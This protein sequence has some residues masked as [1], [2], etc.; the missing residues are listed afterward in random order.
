MERRKFM[1][2]LG[3]AAAGSAALVGSGAFSAMTS[4]D[5]A[6]TV[7][8]EN[9]ADAYLGLHPMGDAAGGLGDEEG[10]GWAADIDDDGKLYLDFGSGDFEMGPWNGAGVNPDSTYQFDRVFGIANQG[11]VSGSTEDTIHAWISKN[12][13]SRVSFYWEGDQSPAD[14][15]DDAEDVKATL[16]PGQYAKVGLEID[17]SGLDEGDEITGVIEISGDNEDH[18]AEP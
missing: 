6:V 3:S 16:P 15:G 8:V 11:R 4:G 18:Q 10:N 9:D 7:Q 17:A 1:I 14:Y 5:R 13:M 2:G 12:T